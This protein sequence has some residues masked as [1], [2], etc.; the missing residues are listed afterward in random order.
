MKKHINYSDTK[1]IIFLQVHT[2]AVLTLFSCLIL[3]PCATIFRLRASASGDNALVS[4]VDPGVGGI[5]TL[6]GSN[7]LAD[8]LLNSTPVAAL[9]C[10]FKSFNILTS[11]VIWSYSKNIN[12]TYLIYFMMDPHWHIQNPGKHLRLSFLRKWLTAFR[13]EFWMR[14]GMDKK[15]KRKKETKTSRQLLVEIQQ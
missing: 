7:W 1:Y 15:K 10:A 3:S 9:Y 5:F 6:F 11:A 14:L 2:L 8:G 12:A 13:I 4:V